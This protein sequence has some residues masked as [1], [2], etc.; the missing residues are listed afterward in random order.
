MT[1]ARPVYRPGLRRRIGHAR[2]LAALLLRTGLL[3]SGGPGRV[4]R[5]LGALR[6]WGTSLAGVLA[7]A[8]AHSPSRPALIDDEGVLTFAELDDRTTRL[9]IGLPLHGPR[10]RVGVLCRNHRGMVET[11]V[12]CSRRGAEV[13][14]LNTGFGTGQIRAVLGELR[15]ALIVA[16]AEFA[17]LLANVPI[18]LRRTVL[19]ADRRPGPPGGDMP[20]AAP[21]A[22]PPATVPPAT[23]PPPP[24]ADPGP[25]D[26]G[27]SI[28]EVIRSV[29]APDTAPGPPQIQSR[30][31]MLSS[32][33]TGR[34]KGARRPP[35]PGLWPLASMTSR[36]PLRTRQTMII[37]APL[38][39]TWGYA[40]LQ[41]AWALRAPIVLHRRFDPERTLGSI[42]AHRDTV[43]FAVP[44]ML[45]RI[46]E[47]APRTRELYDTSSLRIVALS[48]AALPGDLATRFMDAFGDKLYN[49]YGSTEASWVSIAT[50][51]DL[52]LDPRTAGRPPR[53]T[54]LAI[55][56]ADGR[57]VGRSTIGEIFAANELL[58][59]G[60]TG[61][62]PM[63]VRDGLLATGDL[64]HIDHRGLLFVDGRADGMVVSGGENIV[65][66]DVED[67]LMRLPEVDEAAVIG[68]PDDDWGQ[69]LA[70]YIV[71]RPGARLN[72][73]A[74][75]A[76]VHAQVARYAVPRDVH[77][78][79]E[80]PRNA[81]GKV[82]HR[83]LTARTD[84]PRP[85]GRVD[86]PQ[87]PPW[88][89]PAENAG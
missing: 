85:E 2:D 17:P 21:V 6:R 51:R 42:A 7:A 89:L 67:A 54:S 76:Y 58:F 41:M 68:V 84:R 86:W 64:G 49:V 25:A 23:V 4:G 55:V 35:R 73:E 65:P 18:A 74:V 33:T 11:L 79:P 19:W 61:G 30:T 22:A 14:L 43:V 32:G 77:F 3:L 57:R 28:D 45:Q 80:L 69:R 66:G 20:L 15:P 60:Y 83:W 13:V 46:L 62:E 27:P 82:V 50:P 38:F 72:A 48:G 5:Q 40:A 75:R 87:P 71:L 81:T 56:G 37:E 36:I 52:R 10:P 44:V 9:A 88:P 70:A 16:D 59:E 78:I 1:H 29:P 34:P 26:T 12:A 63:Q 31:I 53:N 8:A 47:L 24:R 39:H